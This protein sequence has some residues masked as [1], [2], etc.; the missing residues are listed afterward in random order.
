MSGS[1][2]APLAGARSLSPWVVAGVSAAAAA[3]LLG[4]STLSGAFLVLACLGLALGAV[5]LLTGQPLRTL[6]CGYVLCAPIAISKA[7]ATG[8]GVYAPALELT[9]ADLFL[10]AIVVVKAGDVV[11]R[12]RRPLAVEPGAGG[13][14][15]AVGLP[16][17]L[18]FFGWAWVSALHAPEP[19]HGL[20]AALN[21]T[22]YLGAFLVVARLVRTADDLRWVLVAAA[23]GLSLQVGMAAL[24]FA[25]GSMIVLP[26]IKT[27]SS[28]TMGYNLSY[29]GGVS[30]FRPSGLLQHPV[31]LAGYLAVVLPVPVALMLVG[32]RR[33]G[34][35]AWMLC[36]ALA[37]GGTVALLLTLSRGGWLALA[38][39][40]GF[41]ALTGLHLRL[42]SRLQLVLAVVLTLVG[43]AVTVAAYPQILHRITGSDQRSAESRMLMMEQAWSIIQRNPVLG[44]GMSGYVD[45]ARVH[46]PPSYAALPPDFRET[47]SSGVVHNA[48]LVFWAERGIVGL[49][50]ALLVFGWFV[51]AFFRQRSWEDV[52]WQA[53][54]LGITAGV[55]GQLAM[56]FFDHGYLDSRPGVIWPA[57]G[58]L[59]AVLR[60]QPRADTTGAVPAGGAG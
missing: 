16:A 55:V 35:R 8:A 25:S 22:K 21:L 42:V 30:A 46:R 38:A 53:L 36:V 18:L 14:A 4:L 50:T 17:V 32:P 41:L 11:L 10:V 20:L 1:V 9:L 57:L 12:G 15:R 3:V 31:F 52:V 56:Y 40:I 60:L 51:R 48:Y 54:A 29:A 43:G 34:Q 23:A 5:M 44:V 28:A 27:S 47:L 2:A 33:L 45:A 37:A 39:A 6:L 13:F 58:L 26:G 7:V 24:Q 49:A 19:S 59:A